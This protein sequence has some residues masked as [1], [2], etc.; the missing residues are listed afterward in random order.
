MNK[1]TLGDR[2]IVVGVPVCESWVGYGEAVE[3]LKLKK[4]LLRFGVIKKSWLEQ[5]KGRMLDWEGKAA[6][7]FAAALQWQ[8]R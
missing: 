5:L 6:G 1:S 8:G 2:A 4:K 7:S 3:V